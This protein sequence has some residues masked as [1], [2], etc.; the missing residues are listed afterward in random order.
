MTEFYVYFKTAKSN[1]DTTYRKDLDV[2][3]Q[4][5]GVS[6]IAAGTAGSVTAG[7]GTF[8]IAKVAFELCQKAC[9]SQRQ[10]ERCISDVDQAPAKLAAQAQAEA[11]SL[12]GVPS[13]L[14]KIQRRV[15]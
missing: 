13:L 15:S 7:A 8:V 12:P 11:E 5:G 1:I 14:S 10:V 4:A 9:R 2:C 3:D 6:L